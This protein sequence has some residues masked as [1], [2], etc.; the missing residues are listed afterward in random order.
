MAL[1]QQD[2]T[3]KPESVEAK[4]NYADWPL[5][6]KNWDQCTSLQRAVYGGL[7]AS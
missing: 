4:V 6:L 7:V 5:L 1:V 3:I 2:F